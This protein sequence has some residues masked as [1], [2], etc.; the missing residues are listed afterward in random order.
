[1]EDK[2]LGSGLWRLWSISAQWCQAG[3]GCSET[4]K[5][6]NT[7]ISLC[8][9]EGLTSAWGQWQPGVAHYQSKEDHCQVKQAYSIHKDGLIPG[10]A[11]SH[12]PHL[13]LTYKKVLF[14]KLKRKEIVTLNTHRCNLVPLWV[15]NVEREEGARTCKLSMNL[16]VVDTLS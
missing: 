11:F 12:F 2:D 4:K 14:W 15:S 16:F 10:G 5:H 8:P 13:N 9:P 1:M 3:L 6:R 7:S